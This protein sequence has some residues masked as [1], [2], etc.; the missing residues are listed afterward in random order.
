MDEGSRSQQPGPINAV[1]DG[2]E[3]PGFLQRLRRGLVGRPRDLSDRSIFHH[4]SLIPFLAWV[5]LGADGLSSSCYGP[6]EAFHALGEHTYLALGLAAMTALTVG[7]I[8]T[9]YSHVIE[10][11]PHG[12]GGYVVATKLLG[13]RAGVVS[14]SALVVDYVL[15]ITISIA[16]ACDA[17]FSF[18][19]TAWGEHKLI[20]AVLLILALTILN[21]RGVRESTLVLTPIFITFLAT[22][23]ILIGGGIIAHAPELPATLADA[24]TGYR[25]GL[26]TLGM[27]GMLLLFVHAY[28]LGGGTYTGIEAVSNG[29]AIMREP[30]VQT[31]KRTM[32]YMAV[33]LAFTAGGLLLCYL[34]WHV[35]PEEGKT[36]NAVL[37]ERFVEAVPL[38]RPFVLLVLVAEG[39][40]LVVAAQAGFVDGPRVLANMANDSWVPRRFAALSDRLTTQNGIM[41]MGLAST[42]ALLYTRGNVSK[43]VV[44]YSINV[45][46]TFSMTLLS[47]TR[48][49]IQHRASQPGWKRELPIHAGGLVLC[50]LILGIT[51][52]EKFFLGGWITLVVTGSLVALCFVIRRHYR[53][54][55]ARLVRLDQDMSVLERLPLPAAGVERDVDPTRPTAVILVGGYSGIG[56]HTIMHVHRSF[57]HV[58][59]NLVFVSVGVIDSGS[60][61]GRDE[62]DALRASTEAGLMRYVNLARR[63][64]FAATHRLAI[65][66]EAV[67]GV[68]KL[69]LE[70]GSE[71][72]HCVFFAGQLI[73]Q[74]DRW[75][76]KI[77][78]NQTAF[79]IQQRLQWHDKTMV[80][81]PIRVRN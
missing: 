13:P 27:G 76:Q 60:F 30:R 9:A 58:F 64:G 80:I 35:R 73:F 53:D 29:L 28:S 33:S 12:G 50:V 21:F 14:G 70:V 4:L 36:L 74:R 41:L 25:E 47:M 77:L 1:P 10:H 11:F 57:P 54:V 51:V 3:P 32:F 67:G 52:F 23:V 8:A 15:T 81:L 18:L 37:V 62:V 16:A 65:G 68:E 2:D 75:Y 26:S 45:F 39:A 78:H 61:K 19:P 43:I 59:H 7:V 22:H 31:G 46:V 79:S 72:S 6:E 71:F 34:L 63:L 38:G 48:H 56:V 5:G 44:M 55:Q 40:L 42:A 24:R 69:C 17:L 20:V 49:V 66:T